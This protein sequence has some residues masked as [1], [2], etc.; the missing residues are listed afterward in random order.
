M[1]RASVGQPS[2]LIGRKC[3]KISPAAQFIA[4]RATDRRKSQTVCGDELV[5]CGAKVDHSIPV[6]DSEDREF[7]V[8]VLDQVKDR[9]A[10]EMLPSVIMDNV[11]GIQPLERRRQAMAYLDL[12]KKV[13]KDHPRYSKQWPIKLCNFLHSLVGN[14]RVK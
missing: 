6:L 1:F 12:V 4:S 3:A 7:W 10:Q 13:K 11:V 5:V 2:S 9:R 8:R 14:I